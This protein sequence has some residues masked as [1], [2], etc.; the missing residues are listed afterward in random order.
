[1]I[2]HPTF[3]NYK[4][5]KGTD[6]DKPTAGAFY[7]PKKGDSLSKIAL[8][9][10]G[11]GTFASIQKINKNPYN[12][13]NV[14]YRKTS[15]SCTS[16]L[17]DSATVTA[18]TSWT[19]KSQGWLSLCPGDR[20]DIER[21]IGIA[22]PLVW[23]PANAGDIPKKTTSGISSVL[24]GAIKPRVIKPSSLITEPE[25]YPEPNT[26][27]VEP[28]S[29]YFPPEPSAPQVQPEPARAGM[30]PWLVGLLGASALGGVVWLIL[31]DK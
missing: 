27:V 24:R 19:S 26:P 15:T 2:T 30:S 12:L 18:M 23:I 10:Y 4:I 31:R 8:A 21:Q 13:S 28:D 14:K 22:Y 9:A 16:A 29:V 7:A 20:G 5:F 17:V 6:G 11:S 25:V 1:M 3:T